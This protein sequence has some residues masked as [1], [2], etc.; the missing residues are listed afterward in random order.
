MNL[1]E[2]MSHAIENIIQNALKSTL[3]NPKE[4]AFLLNYVF[5]QRAAEQKRIASDKA[6][7]HIPPF[8]IASITTHCNLFC[9]GCYA[10]ANHSCGEHLNQNELS[11]QKWGRIFEE[12]AEL[13]ISFILL[14]GGEPLMRREVIEK[15]AAVPQIIFPVFTNGTMMDETYLSLFNKNRNLVPVLSIE[16][17]QVQTDTRRGEGTY[18]T[19]LETMNNMNQ[20]GIFYGASVTVTT[21]N[22]DT[23][24]NEEFVSGLYQRGCKL[25]IFVEYVPVTSSTSSLAPGDEERK[26]LEEKQS[27][28]REEYENMIFISFPGDEKH[29]GGCLA[30]GRGFFHINAVGGAEPC[31]FSPFSDTNLQDCSLED[32]LQ[33]PIFLK[34]RDDGML[35]GE[36]DGGCVLFGQ[37]NKVRNMLVK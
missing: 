24:T 4:S 27:V 28:L 22:L 10:R 14:A 33:S 9:K 18:E 30:A 36:H 8:L 21:E 34:L 17:N 7:K 16:G 13:G 3:K 20:L 2:Y 37:E 29:T 32:A 26:I 5:S 31:P 35:S 19:L 6:G 15:A 12:A 1:T 25:I 11:N 23:V